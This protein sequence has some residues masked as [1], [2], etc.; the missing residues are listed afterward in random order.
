GKWSA[1]D[2]GLEMSPLGADDFP[3]AKVLTLFRKFYITDVWEE[4]ELGSEGESGDEE[5]VIRIA[6]PVLETGSYAF[7]APKDW[8]ARRAPGQIQVL[9]NQLLAAQHERDL[10][11]E[12]YNEYVRGITIK[13]ERLSLQLRRLKASVEARDTAEWKLDFVD[14]A[15]IALEFAEE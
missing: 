8:G 9:I 7:Q 4:L 10:A 14:S 5:N 13:C 6:A 12:A 3:P 2:S 15:L 11:L 1:L